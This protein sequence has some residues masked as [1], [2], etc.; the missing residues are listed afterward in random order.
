MKTT[1]IPARRR[2]L[3]LLAGCVALLAACDKSADGGTNDDTSTVVAFYTKDGRPA[4]GAAVKIF[5]SSDTSR[6][7]ASKVYTNSSGAVTMPAL[8]AG[9]YNILVEGDSGDVA[10][11]DSL[12]SDGKNLPY[13]SDTL[14]GAG[15]VTGRV[16]VQPNDDPRIAWVSLLGAGKNDNVD[17][18]GRFRFEGVP[19]GTY[20]LVVLTDRTGYTRTFRAPIVRRDSVTDLGDIEL[21]YTGMPVATGISALWDSL[22]GT[23]RIR[24]DSTTS[25]KVQGWQILRSA[26]KYFSDATSIEKVGVEATEFVDTLVGMGRL[27]ASSDTARIQLRY[28]VVPIDRLGAPGTPWNFVDVEVRPAERSNTRTP[29]WAL[30]GNPGLWE[31]GASRMLDTIDGGFV[32]SEMGWTGLNG[33]IQEHVLMSQDGLTWS[34][35]AA[36]EDTSGDAMQTMSW[37][38]SFAGRFWWVEYAG[39]SRMVPVRGYGEQLRRDSVLVRGMDHSGKIVERRSALH[40]SA[41]Y[42][43]LVNDGRELALL[44]MAGDNFVYPREL[45][46]HRERWISGATWESGPSAAAWIPDEMLGGYPVSAFPSSSGAP[47]IQA[48]WSTFPI[49]STAKLGRNGAEVQTNWVYGLR[50]LGGRLAV[51]EGTKGT[52]NAPLQWSDSA[53][54]AVR[55]AVATPGRVSTMTSRGDTL[56]ILVGDSLYRAEQPLGN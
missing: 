34:Q 2:I 37:G 5:A 40:D 38:V 8:A 55:H 46:R 16:R 43:V 4:V 27:L 42:A 23:T 7:P 49:S 15:V 22:S 25:G 21:V 36:R 44:H 11:Q 56:W 9:Y 52:E 10:F 53:T 18:S 19:E 47:W 12:V 14:V 35:I 1:S 13:R 20:S 50:E 6:V 3:T 33:N 32:M 17:E 30:L 45:V 28:W 54:P 26:S 48:P 39:K 24:W 41:Q 31:D 29:S 51:L